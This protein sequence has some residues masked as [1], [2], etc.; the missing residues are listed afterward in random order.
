M[1][2][3]PNLLE[4]SFWIGGVKAP[5]CVNETPINPIKALTGEG[6]G[7][8]LQ[9]PICVNGTPIKAMGAPFWGGRG[10]KAEFGTP[11][12]PIGALVLDWGAV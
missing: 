12:E 2:P 8:G 9:T 4:P 6:G 3:P 1:G 10:V 11:T 5:I 7:G